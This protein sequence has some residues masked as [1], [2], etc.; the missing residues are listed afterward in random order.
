MRRRA[1]LLIVA[2]TVCLVAAAGVALAASIT[3]PNSI[4]NLCVGTDEADTMTGTN[5][6]DDMRGRGG[7]DTMYALGGDDK[8]L[9]GD[10][11]DDISAGPGNDPSVRGGPG[12]ERHDPH[13]H[14]HKRKLRDG[15]RGIDQLAPEH[16]AQALGRPGHGVEASHLIIVPNTS[17][18][19]H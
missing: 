8:A 11:N 3:C 6:G 19:A 9:G 10:G 7:G 13:R 18:I 1:V 5:Q 4:G 12:D 2:M 17:R 16:G 15:Q 14:R